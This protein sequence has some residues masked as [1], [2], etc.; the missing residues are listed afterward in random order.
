MTGF[1]CSLPKKKL[2]SYLLH[3]PTGQARVRIAGRDH[4][5]GSYG[6]EA[7]RVAYGQLISRHAS[8]LPIDPLA[9]SSC[10]KPKNEDP[11]PSVAE[12][13]LIFL[14]HA[15]HHYVKEGKQTSEVHIVK[16]VIRPLRELYGMLPA[17]DFGPLAL[18]A[19]RSKMIE[20]GWARNT[21]NAGMSRIRRIFKHAIE[22]EMI[23]ATVLARLQAVAP[24]LAGRTE[25][26]D[27]APRQPVEQAHIDAVLKLVSTR[28]QDLI[29]LQRLTGARSGELLKLTTGIIDRTGL[30]WTARVA[31]HKNEH[32][33]HSRTL[34]F[35]PKAQLILARYLSADRDARLFQILRSAYCRAITRACEKAGIPRWVPHQLRHNGSGSRSPAVWL[36]THSICSWP[37]KGQHERALR[38]S[39]SR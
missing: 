36:G 14:Q 34:V 17:K 26:R 7:S 37:C 33:G 10:G 1:V 38:K 8:G 30:V 31:G 20:L 35:G 39:R 23:D 21:I 3:K 32:H 5:L 2:P 24:L 9:K 12:L 13:C 16:S 27:N 11:G 25:A 15:E 6:S 22:N 29:A 18:K 4:Y 28:V 19:V